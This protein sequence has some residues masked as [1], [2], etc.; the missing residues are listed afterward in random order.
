[1]TGTVK[2]TP[3]EAVMIACTHRRMIIAAR[4]ALAQAQA[5]QVWAE[6]AAAAAVELEL[7]AE[8]SER[9]STRDKR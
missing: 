7:E 6:D 4:T 9:A 3:G 8:G 1:M 2:L 5:C